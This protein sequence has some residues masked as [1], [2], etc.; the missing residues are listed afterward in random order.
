VADTPAADERRPAGRHR[1]S[2]IPL[3]LLYTGLIV[4]AS[5]YPFEGWRPPRAG[6]TDFLGLP[7]PRWWT[8][9]DLVSNLLGY[10]PVGLLL[11]VAAVR[12]GWRARVAWPAACAAGLVL[13]LVMETLQNFLPQRVPSNLDA[14]LNLAGTAA[15]AG[16]GALAHARGGVA[17]WQTLRDRWFAR[18][19]ASGL[20][21]LVLWPVGLLFPLPLPLAVGQV[22]PR[23]RDAVVASLAGTPAEDWVSRWLDAGA[24]APGLAPAG[25]FLVVVLGLLGP[26]LVAFSVSLPGWRRLVLS[27]GALLLG[28]ATTTL[29]TA[30]NFAPQHAL[31]WATPEAVNAIALA[32]LLA[33]ALVWLPR[34]AAAALGLVALTALVVL[35]AQAPTDPYYSFSLQAWEQGRFIRFHGAAQWVGWLWPY[36]AMLHLLVAIGARRT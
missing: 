20:A 29:S 34:R 15:G 33:L 16:L 30:L 21:L 25:D 19:S 11:F 1:S 31:A 26:C 10:L 18:R 35:V 6:I 28:V 13:S 32:T 3:A 7:W 4:Y 5:L 8:G 12:S 23:V 17:R 27:L 14:A 22:I 2:A 36:A 24:K 9:F